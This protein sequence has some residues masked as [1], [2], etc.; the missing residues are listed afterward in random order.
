[1]KNDLVKKEFPYLT[2]HRRIISLATGN[3][4]YLVR[5]EDLS[6]K[7]EKELFEIL[8]HIDTKIDMVNACL[9]KHAAKVISADSLD[10]LKYHTV[11]FLVESEI[12]RRLIKYRK[13]VERKLS[14]QKRLTTFMKGNKKR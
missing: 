4:P 10:N 9:K 13:R 2:N 6:K 3:S 7:D 11:S 5:E 12:K 1:M 8:R 14:V